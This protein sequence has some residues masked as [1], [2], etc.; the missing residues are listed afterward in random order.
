MV[1]KE[2]ISELTERLQ[3]IENEIKLLQSDKRELLSD[4]SDK[5]D[6]KAFKAAWSLTKAKKNINDSE[7]EQILEMLEKNI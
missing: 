6:I 7:F 5:I 4:F 2:V 1:T 3:S